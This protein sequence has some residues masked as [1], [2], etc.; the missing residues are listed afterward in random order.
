LPVFGLQTPDTHVAFGPQALPQKPQ[1]FG[2]VL[3]LASHPS[4][5]W[6]SQSAKP[7]SHDAMAHAAITQSVVPCG[8]GPQMTPHPPQ[9]LLSDTRFAHVRPQHVWLGGQVWFGPHVPTQTPPEQASPGGHALKQPPQLLGSSPMF[10]SQPF[11]TTVSQSAKPGVHP[12]SAQAPAVQ[13]GIALGKGPQTLPQA[14]Q[15]DGSVCVSTQSGLQHVRPFMHAP[16]APQ[17]PTQWKLEQSSPVGHWP[18]FTHST[19]VCVSRRQC[20]VGAAHSASEVHPPGMGTHVCVVVSHLSP[21]GQSA[22]D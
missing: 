9:L 6:V 15:L 5:T 16:P 18:L 11:E 21:V 3:V 22:F 10:V 14:P 13:V 1:L 2:S 17:K 4:A 19:Q 12:R 8:T 7:T 20:G